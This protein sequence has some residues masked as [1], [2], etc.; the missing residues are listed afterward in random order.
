MIRTSTNSVAEMVF[1]LGDTCL[2]A[3]RIDAAGIDK[4][5]ARYADAASDTRLATPLTDGMLASLATI[6][7]A[8]KVA[9][10]KPQATEA[11][12]LLGATEYV[13]AD[14]GPADANGIALRSRSKLAA[15]NNLGAYAVSAD[16]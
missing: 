14:S 10:L 11:K 3:D 15:R 13:V 16:A 9:G 1:Q 12:R 5:L 2:P 7:E 8:C 6:H 4:R